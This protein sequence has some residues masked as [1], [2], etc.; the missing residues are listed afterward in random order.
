MPER[1]KE[2]SA[3]E[4]FAPNAIVQPP[5]A[6]QIQGREAIRRLYDNF[7]TMVEFEGTATTIVP[8]ASGDLAYEY[9]VNWMVFETPEC[10]RISDSGP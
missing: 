9:G 1:K 3:V 6:V 7:E 2:D 4:F 10:R 8:A 5:G